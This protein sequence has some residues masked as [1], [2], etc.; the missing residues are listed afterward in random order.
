MD[1]TRIKCKTFHWDFLPKIMEFQ[2][3]PA[4][5]A[6]DRLGVVFCTH[7]RRHGTAWH[8]RREASKK[9]R[10]T[11]LSPCSSHQDLIPRN[12]ITPALAPHRPPTASPLACDCNYNYNYSYN[13]SYSYNVV[14]FRYVSCKYVHHK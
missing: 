10:T 13:Y 4:E 3:T 1:A 9:G 6:V 2:N 11:T 8:G 14:Y 12:P 5:A 7:H